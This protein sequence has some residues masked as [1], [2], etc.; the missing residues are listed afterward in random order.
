MSAGLAFYTRVGPTATRA[1]V[2]LDHELAAWGRADRTETGLL[3]VTCEALRTL[4]YWQDSI[5]AD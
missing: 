2:G 1:T 4:A 5:P 3:E